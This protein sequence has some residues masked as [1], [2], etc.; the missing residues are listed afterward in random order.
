MLFIIIISLMPGTNNISK[1][2]GKQSLAF[3]KG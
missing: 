3:K 1:Q 2:T